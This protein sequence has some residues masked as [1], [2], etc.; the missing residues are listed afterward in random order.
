MRLFHE[1]WG[2]GAAAIDPGDS[3]LGTGVVRRNVTPDSFFHVAIKTRD[4][5]ESVTFYERYFDAS[6]L[7]RGD[8][9]DGAGATAVTHAA[10][11]IADKRIYLFDRA[12]YE[13]AGLVEDVPYGFLHYGFV[14]DDV[15]EV[16]ATLAADGVP[17]IMEPTRFG[18][19]QV[20]FFEDPT[21]VRVELIEHLD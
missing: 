16:S 20:S 17:F 15:V 21:G 10:L 9:A 7:E 18:S 6:V 11:A 2:L 4:V 3:I 8:A 14:V 5:E 12:P 19:L 1:I 13:A